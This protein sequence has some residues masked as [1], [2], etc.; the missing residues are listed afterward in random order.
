MFIFQWQFDEAQMTADNVAMP[1]TQAQWNFIHHQGR[2]TRRTLAQAA[3]VFSPSCISHT[4]LT[5]PSWMRVT[6]AGTSLPDALQCW[7]AS[8]PAESSH[9]PSGITRRP[10]RRTASPSAR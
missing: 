3:A 7:A 4:V 5:K 6:V 9:V 8:L 10:T 1:S 2:N